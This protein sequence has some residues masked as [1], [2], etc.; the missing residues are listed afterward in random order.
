MVVFAVCDDDI[1]FT[2]VLYNNLNNILIS[3]PSTIEYKVLQYTSSK[4]LLDDI[5]IHPINILLLDIDMPNIN[6]F[7]IAEIL[8]KKSPDTIIIFVSAYDNLV[9]DSFQFNP[10]CFLRKNHL[11]NELMPTIQKVLNVF[12]EN[13]NTILFKTIEGNINVRVKDINFIESNK[14][15]YEINMISGRVY[16]CRGTLSSIEAYLP[17][18]DFYRIHKAF[19]I[20]FNNIV[21]VDSNRKITIANKKYFYV[22]LRKW[23]S[24]KSLYMDFSRKRVV[25]VWFQR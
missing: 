15:Y 22:S 3:A 19:I 24:F 14:N 2:K 17:S 20:N 25:L 21:S 1:A 9:Y 12:F 6:G 16:K 18:D 8:Q 13:N 5:S 4:Q 10:F 7:Q 23:S 11:K